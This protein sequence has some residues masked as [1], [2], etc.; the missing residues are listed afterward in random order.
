MTHRA[1]TM[2]H[3]ILALIATLAA[4]FAET[5][6]PK[7]IPP[8]IGH[9]V[10]SDPGGKSAASEW[11]ITLTLPKI[12]WEITGKVVPKQEWPELKTEVSMATLTLRMGGPSA[13]AE[14]RIVDTKGTAIPRAEVMKRLEKPTPVLVSLSGRIPDSYH[15]QLTTPEALILLLGPRDGVPAPEFLPARKQSGEP[16]ENVRR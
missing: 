11:K 7:D 4:A 3:H 1:F 14:S 13:L 5:P 10:I 12:A 2:K 15:L 9:A 16:A 6:A 8:V